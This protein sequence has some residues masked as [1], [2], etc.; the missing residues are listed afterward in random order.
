M[1]ICGWVN[2]ADGTKRWSLRT[3]DVGMG[4]VVADDPHLVVGDVLEL[5]RRAD[6]AEG[7]DP[8]DRCLLE[9]VDDHQPGVRVDGDPRRER[10]RGG[11]RWG[12]DRW[13]RARRR[14]RRGGRRPRRR[15][16][17]LDAR[18]ADGC[19]PLSS[20]QRRRA[21]AVNAAEMSSSCVRSRR[22]PRITWMT[23]QPKASNTWANSAAMNPPPKMIDRP[24]QLVELH[25]RVGGVDARAEL[26][27]RRSAGTVARLPAAT[28]QRSAVTTVP[29]PVSS[30]LCPTNRAVPVYTVMFGHSGPSRYALPAATIGSM[31]PNTRSR[32]AGQSTASTRHR[33]AERRRRRGPRRR[34]RRGARTSSSGRS[35]R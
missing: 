4:E 7:E 14:R 12:P 33:H 31:R 8:V 16:R 27:T 24:R 10:R 25:D 1:A 21:A 26:Q 6:V 9:L 35:R 30:R 34:G 23:S 5:P 11:R 3:I 19:V 15:R 29:V 18:N 22:S 13:R 17:S 28:T 2:T 32:S 20:V